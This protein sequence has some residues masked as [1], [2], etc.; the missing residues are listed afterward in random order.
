M[1]VR[2][3]QVEHLTRYRYEQW[4]SHAQHIAMLEP[5]DDD[6]QTC[7][8]SQLELDP[9]PD[10][11]AGASRRDVFG[12]RLRWF[13]LSQAHM[14][15]Q[16]VARSRV[17]VEPLHADAPVH[18]PQASPTVAEVAE[19]LRYR[20]GQCWCA[21]LEFIQVSP[22][23]PQLPALSALAQRTLAPS[24]PV[25]QAALDLMTSIHRTFTY[26]SHS[27]A[28]DTPLEQVLDQ[29]TGVCQDFAHVM[30]GALR[31]A[32]VPA[33]YVSG[34]L[35]TD[36]PAGQAALVGADAS[37][38]WVQVWSPGPTSEHP[39]HWTDL[40]PTNACIV[41]QDHIRVAVG[42]DFGDVTPL[43][44]VI[45]GGGRHHLSV[46]VTTRSWPDGAVPTG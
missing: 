19:S 13:S 2:I 10:A 30:V 3:L 20:P 29:Q 21:A 18:R 14:E 33:R 11:A 24:T 36:P 7:L 31:S 23:V 9:L 40:D 6:R 35:R 45:R 39:G 43:K 12:N 25:L 15:F 17:R 32:G 42:R 16:A 8:W 44:G 28:I 22:Y 38:A 5:L 27:T 41:D 4:V 34:Y 1:S 26:R 46:A 37:H